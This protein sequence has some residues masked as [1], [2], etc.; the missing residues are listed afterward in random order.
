M[1]SNGACWHNPLFLN[2]VDK[3]DKEAVLHVSTVAQQNN[4]LPSVPHGTSIL[5]PTVPLSTQLPACGVGKQQI[6]LVLGPLLLASDHS[7]LA[8]EATWRANQPM[9][10]LSLAL[11]FFLSVKSAFQIFF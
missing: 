11:V 8:V 2:S 1:I 6:A 9:E 10:V 5:V 4:L 7:A 3:Q